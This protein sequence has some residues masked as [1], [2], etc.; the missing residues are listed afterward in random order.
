MP[1]AP[2]VRLPPP[3][4]APTTDLRVTRAR[5]G[6]E[7]AFEQLYREH[8]GR[9]NALCLRLCGD[10]ARAEELTQRTFVKAWTS[11]G[12]FRG[13]AAFGTWLHRIAVRVVLDE[14]RSPWWRRRQGAVPERG[15]R[16]EPGHGV[17]LERALADLPPKAR[18][19]LVLHDVEGWRHQDVA[20]AL[21]ISVGTSKSQ[22][23]RARRLLRERLS[24]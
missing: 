20:E 1:A 22:L 3:S 17:D 21:G 24:S 19:V 4:P 18:Q 16:P 2:E 12:R 6:D 11:L 5:Q 14:E 15:H 7:E 23:G 13:E 9:V 10:P 8:V